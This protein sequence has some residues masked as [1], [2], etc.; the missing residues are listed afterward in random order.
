MNAQTSGLDV[1]DKSSDFSKKISGKWRFLKFE[2]KKISGRP[3]IIKRVEPRHYL[4]L[5]IQQFA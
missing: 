2:K 5:V 3:C 4:L 1:S